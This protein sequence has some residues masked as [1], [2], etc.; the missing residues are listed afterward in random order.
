MVEINR[1][2]LQKA[3]GGMFS[4]PIKDVSY[5]AELM[6]G[7][8]V[9]EVVRVSGEARTEEKKH[10]FS[11]VVKTQREWLRHGDPDCWKREYCIYE[12]NLENEL[13]ATIKLPRC[14]LLEKSE[15]LTRIWME[16][17]E[18]KTGSR[19]LHADELALAACRLGEL[20]AG[21][22]LSG[23]RGLPYLR[24]YP[25]VQS[26]Y[27]LWSKRMMPLLQK[28][29]DG[30]PD[31]LRNILC[32][33]AA[34]AKDLL[35]SFSALPQTLC[36]GDVHHDNLIF[37]DEDGETAIYLI[38]WDSAGYGHMGEDAVDVLMEAFVYSDRDVSLLPEFREKIISGYCKGAK[39]RGLDFVMGEPLVRELFA[40]AWGFRIAD[41]FLYYKEDASRK[42]CIE[43]MSA[44]L[45]R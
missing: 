4:A 6:R 37:R 3:L 22:H 31:R 1:E 7:G 35:G 19:Q 20:Q 39:S 12:Q 13:L 28:E 41:L 17:V 30:F 10:P 16:F 38:D 15:G 36:H 24:A 2:S 23:S 5:T 18:G 44:M 45:T 43:I 40:L 27:D 29:I 9:G 26:S 42:R 34:C 25:A 14:F 32:D 21:F 11:L 8:T 33:Y